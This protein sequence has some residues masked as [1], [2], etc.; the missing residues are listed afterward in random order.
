MVSVITEGKKAERLETL[1]LQYFSLGSYAELATAFFASLDVE[2]TI[3]VA[4]KVKRFS[5]ASLSASFGG[6][7]EPIGVGGAFACT[8]DVSRP[9]RSASLHIPGKLAGAGRSRVSVLPCEIAK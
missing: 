4:N 5:L 6:S 9:R 3:H 2:A 7:C 1:L 8:G